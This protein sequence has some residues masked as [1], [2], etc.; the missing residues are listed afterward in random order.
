MQ[1][2]MDKGDFFWIG[3]CIG[4]VVLVVTVMFVA[5]MKEKERKEYE[6]KQKAAAAVEHA[7]SVVLGANTDIKPGIR[8]T[9]DMIARK[10]IGK[11]AVTEDMFTQ[12]E[13]VVDRVT[14]RAIKAGM[15]L[16]EDD[17]EPLPGSDKAEN[18]SAE[19]DSGN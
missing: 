19:D 8:I 10:T 13:D 11:S 9:A 4:I 6:A 16:T 5:P 2:G 12:P 3:N 15:V 1:K 14:A 7:E 17:L 18:S